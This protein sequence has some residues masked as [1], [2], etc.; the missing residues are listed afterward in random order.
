VI[1]VYFYRTY[2][3]QLLLSQIVEMVPYVR[4][5]RRKFHWSIGGIITGLVLFTIAAVELLIV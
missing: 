2:G 5:I 1:A 4:G 3:K